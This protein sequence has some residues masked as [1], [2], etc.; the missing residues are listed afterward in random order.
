M[1]FK[2]FDD[3]EANERQAIQKARGSVLDIGCGAG[4]HSLYLKKKGHDVTGIDISP[5][6][7]EVCRKR[8]L[9]DSHVLTI[10]DLPIAKKYRTALLLGNNLGL[11]AKRDR[12][13]KFLARIGDLVEP[14]GVLIANSHNV[15]RETQ[16]RIWCKQYATPWMDRLLVSPRRRSQSRQGNPVGK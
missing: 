6:A 16:I 13:A 7:I 12:L 1:Y 8:G 2:E 11:A 4:R 9:G 15:D 10:N 14:D 3:W 5:L